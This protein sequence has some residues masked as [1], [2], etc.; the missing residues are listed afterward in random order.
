MDLHGI[1]MN[2]QNVKQ[3]STEQLYKAKHQTNSEV[4]VVDI[5]DANSYAQGHV[6]GS[7]NLN[8]DNI[9]EFVDNNKFEQPIVVVCYSGHSSIGAV[10]VLINVGFEDVSSLEGGMGAWRL[11]H[12]NEVEFD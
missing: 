12:P 9:Q 5:R 6:P 11:Q 2:N 10:G 1:F 4:I 3:I 7:I 8:N